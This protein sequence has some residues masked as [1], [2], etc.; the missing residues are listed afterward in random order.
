M[1]LEKDLLAYRDSPL[2]TATRRQ[3]GIDLLSLFSLEPR[4]D[5]AAGLEANGWT[6]T[7]HTPFD[8]TRRHGR[9]PLPEPNDALAGNRWVFAGRAGS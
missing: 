6:T 8:F 2:Y 7:V 5:S 3:I 1:K 9:G 4:P